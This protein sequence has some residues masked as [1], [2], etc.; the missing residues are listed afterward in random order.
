[1]RKG[2]IIILVVYLFFG[3]YFINYAFNFITLPEFVNVID[4]WLILVGGLLILF[5]GINFFR[6]RRGRYSF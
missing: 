1:M 5:G 3:V 4:K 6:A 2:G